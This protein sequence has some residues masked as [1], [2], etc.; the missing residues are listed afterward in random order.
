MSRQTNPRSALIT[1][2]AGGIGVAIAE[3]L[4]AKGYKIAVADRDSAGARGVAM[5]LQG[6]GHAAIEIDVSDERSVR[7]AIDET[8]QS[9]GPVN[10]L[11]HAAGVMFTQSDG[12]V[13]PFWES[14]VDRWDRTMNINARGTFLV[15]AEFMRRRVALPVTEGR[16]VLFSSLLAQ[17]AGNRT[18]GDYSASKSAVLGFMRAAA[19][20][21]ASFGITVNA[22]SPGQIETPMLRANIPHGV[23]VSEQVLM[24]RY[25]QPSDIAAAVEYIVD[26]TTSFVTGATFD[27]NGG[28]RFQ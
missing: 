1:G 18:Y 13:L 23:P 21:C 14:G 6:D 8:E 15:A 16:I 9:V 7:D 3:R 25:G 2:G 11:V 19:R 10:V 17:I 24:R 5:A 26:P 20:E 28:Q 27:V 4:A 12:S 22:I